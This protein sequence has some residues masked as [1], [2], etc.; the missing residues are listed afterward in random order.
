MY[1]QQIPFKAKP[2]KSG[3]SMVVTIPSDFLQHLLPPD[4][5]LQFYIDIPEKEE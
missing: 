4:I 1:M 2:R 5:E 3:D